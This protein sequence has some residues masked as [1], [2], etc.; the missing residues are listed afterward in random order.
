MSRK[1]VL[2]L[3][4]LMLL[5]CL[6]YPRFQPNR[7]R[8]SDGHPV[9]NLNTGLSY[10]TIQEAINANE[11]LDGHVIHVD[12][13]TYSVNGTVYNLINKSVSLVGDGRENTTII[14]TEPVPI[15]HVAVDHV[16]ISGFTMRNGEYGVLASTNFPTKSTDYVHILDCNISDNQRGISMSF[17]YYPDH[18]LV[19]E[20]IEGSILMNNSGLAI[21]LQANSSIIRRNLI[22]GNGGGISLGPG[23]GPEELAT[24]NLVYENTIENHEQRTHPGLIIGGYNNTIFL[25]N[26]LNNTMQ[27][28]SP[29]GA[30]AWDYSMNPDDLLG[31][32]NFWSD[33]N[34]TNVSGMGDVPYVID[35]DNVDHRPLTGTLNIFDAPYGYEVDIISNS[36]ISDFQFSPVNESHAVLS[37]KVSGENGTQGFCRI[38]IPDALID[39]NQLWTVKL[40]GKPI[41]NWFISNWTHWVT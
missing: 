41:D 4:F 38:I 10:T 2:I 29:M 20:I 13:G 28:E 37:V 27:A 14:A 24:G 34:E 16:T 35:S 11:T 22:S 3:V 32:G 12:A 40:D 15:F 23:N 25:N 18:Q 6:G 39:H 30:N 17:P 8:A 1:F 7:A 36:S 21:Y 33:Y 31:G 5:V 19:G 26:F 9:H